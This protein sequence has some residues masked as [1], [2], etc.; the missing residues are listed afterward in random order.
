MRIK[1]GLDSRVKTSFEKFG[2]A[3]AQMGKRKSASRKVDPT[4]RKAYSLRQLARLVPAGLTRVRAWVRHPEWRL[5]ITGPWDVEAVRR[6]RDEVLHPDASLSPGAQED[7]SKPLTPKSRSDL[8]WRIQRG[9][10]EKIK[11]DLE[12]G[13]LHSVADCRTRR[14]R[15]IHELRRSLFRLPRAFAERCVGKSSDE[16]EAIVAAEL[17]ALCNAFAS[18]A[19]PDPTPPGE[20]LRGSN[21]GRRP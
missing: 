2:G 11:A 1:R 9:R 18:A 6:W 3:G 13:L 17:T 19:D 7:A 4:G 10:R 21:E 5:K 8:F 12:E 20:P 14:R 16:I 15:Q